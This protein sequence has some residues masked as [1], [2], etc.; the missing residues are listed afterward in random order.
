M[1][2]TLKTG[3][4]AASSDMGWTFDRRGRIG[5]NDLADHQKIKEHLDG[6]QVLLDRL[7]RTGM[8]FDLSRET[9]RRDEPH[10]IDVLLRRR[11]T[12]RAASCVRLTRVQ[13]PDPGPQKPRGISLRHFRQR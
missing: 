11:Q 6:G 8:L 12:L 10:V 4:F 2:S 13:V 5:R 1:S 9:H 3:R 7:R